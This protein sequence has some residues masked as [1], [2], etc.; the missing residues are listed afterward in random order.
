MKANRRGVLAVSLAAV[1][2]FL[3]NLSFASAEEYEGMKGADSARVFFDM[4]IGLPESAA[5]HMKLMFDTYKQLEDMKKEPVVVVVF[6]GGSVKLISSNRA[7]FGAEDQK[8]LKEIDDIISKM[9]EAGIDLEVCLAAVE[10]FG[11]DPA[12]I[13]PEIRQVP[14]G[15]ISEI[16]YQANGYSLVPVY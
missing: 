9:S 8:Y 14:N 2:L 3:S 13:R 5:L 11:V 7:T 4:R 10:V 1:F 12:S 16:G 15:W 6:I